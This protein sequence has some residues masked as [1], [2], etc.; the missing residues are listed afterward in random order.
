[1]KT[2]GN[3][4]LLLKKQTSQRCSKRFT[5]ILLLLFCF[6]SPLCLFYFLTKSHKV[7]AMTLRSRHSIT[8]K[9]DNLTERHT[10]N[11]KRELLS[12]SRYSPF[13]DHCSSGDM[14]LGV[15]TQRGTKQQLTV[16]THTTLFHMY[17]LKKLPKQNVCPQ[18]FYN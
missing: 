17:F 9:Q 15:L 5:F 2:N 1:M 13:S 3:Q 8:S 18:V 11:S 16:C 7:Q 6:S 12:N 4:G 10:H 14:S